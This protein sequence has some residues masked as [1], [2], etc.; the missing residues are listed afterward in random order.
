MLGHAADY[1]WIAGRVERDLRC[2][3]LRFG[4]PANTSWSG[5]IA[6]IGSVDQ[7]AQLQSGDTVVVKGSLL[8]LGDGGCSSRSY[9]VASIEEH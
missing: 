7:L 6:L 2:T 4:S 5:R 8:A 1:S 3:Y 9:L